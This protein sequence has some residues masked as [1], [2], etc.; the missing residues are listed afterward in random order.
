M[1]AVPSPA[2]QAVTTPDVTQSAQIETQSAQKSGDDA[3]PQAAPSQAATQQPAKQETKPQDAAQQSSGE[4]IGW[5]KLPDRKTLTVNEWAA[6][7][8]NDFGSNTE[9]HWRGGVELQDATMFVKADEADWDEDTHMLNARGHV[10]YHDFEK[11]EQIWCDEMDYNAETQHGY[12]YDVSGETMPKAV[13]RKGVLTGNSPF[14]FEGLWAERIGRRYL[15][16]YGW[17]TDCK[18]PIPGGD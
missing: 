12:F 15:V 7:A 13:V 11:N 17:I 9:H 8:G 4:F 3:A 10:Y 2:Q 1:L 6:I 16:Y 14:H 5:P 18:L